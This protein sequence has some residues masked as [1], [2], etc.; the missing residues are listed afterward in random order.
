MSEPG[1]FEAKASGVYW[2]KDAAGLAAAGRKAGLDVV[3]IRPAAG[4]KA[5]LLD[6]F[7]AALAF[8]AWFGGNWDALEDCL[9]DLSWRKA[10]GWLLLISATEQVPDDDLGV[11]RDVLASVAE[12]WGGRGKP[13]HAVLAGVRN[14]LGL[15]AFPRA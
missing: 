15:P 7:S 3:E 2:A 1:R 9:A 6:A 10:P 8:P 13:F 5:A 4:T 14:P 11:L 12:S